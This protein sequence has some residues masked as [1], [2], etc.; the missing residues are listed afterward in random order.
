M[1]VVPIYDFCDQT[2]CG[3][4]ESKMGLHCRYW[5]CMEL[6]MVGHGANRSRHYLE[7][8][9]VGKRFQLAEGRLRV[10]L[11]AEEGE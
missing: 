3:P 11:R 8:C 4:F 9:L 2:T 5:T 10:P 7:C 1:M 6:S